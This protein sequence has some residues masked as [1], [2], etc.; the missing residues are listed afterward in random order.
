VADLEGEILGGSPGTVSLVGCPS[1]CRA[2]HGLH[3]GEEAWV[4][5]SEPLYVSEG[6]SAQLCMSVDPLTSVQD[7]PY[8][9][10]GS[11]EYTLHQT[12]ALGAALMAMAATGSSSISAPSI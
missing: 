12:Q 1:W 5:L 10:I 7:G 9:L 3:L 4:H 8:V 2:R 6:V 11:A